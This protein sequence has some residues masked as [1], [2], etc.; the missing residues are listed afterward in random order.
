MPRQLAP[1]RS[2]R[3]VPSPTTRLR[4]TAGGRQIGEPK[5]SK[6]LVVIQESHAS[7]QALFSNWK[8]TRRAWEDTRRLTLTPGPQYKQPWPDARVGPQDLPPLPEKA[9]PRDL[10]RPAVL[11]ISVVIF[12]Y[13]LPRQQP[14]KSLRAISETTPRCVSADSVPFG[15]QTTGCHHIRLNSF[16]TRVEAIFISPSMTRIGNL[17]SVSSGSPLQD[18]K[19]PL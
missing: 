6:E 13:V 14:K 2:A 17:Q 4:G 5:G 19:A 16:A 18:R 7:S 9:A 1:R 10:Q 11:R 12:D 8:P 3:Q 15:C